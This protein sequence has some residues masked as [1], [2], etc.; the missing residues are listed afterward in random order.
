MP[1]YSKLKEY[2]VGK[3]RE[4]VDNDKST[5]S[6]RLTALGHLEKLQVKRRPRGGKT[7]GS[8]KKND[9]RINR[10]APKPVDTKLLGAVP[11]IDPSLSDSLLGRV[12]PSPDTLENVGPATGSAELQY[13][14]GVV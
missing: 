10:P 13:K 7:S 8:F 12:E 4:I 14:K 2:L 3:Y 9:K 6:Q 11:A 1:P 5:L